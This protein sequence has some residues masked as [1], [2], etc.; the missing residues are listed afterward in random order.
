MC[1]IVLSLQ[2][3]RRPNGQQE[4]RAS[5]G[6]IPRHTLHFRLVVCCIACLPLVVFFDLAPLSGSARVEPRYVVAS[7]HEPQDDTCWC[8]YDLLRGGR[9]PYQW[10]LSNE[11][12]TR[13]GTEYRV[14]NIQA[15]V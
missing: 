13:K 7:D 1:G 9:E 8:H 12:T 10:D 6:T 5:S 3:P 2:E 14:F 4:V 11:T 15:R